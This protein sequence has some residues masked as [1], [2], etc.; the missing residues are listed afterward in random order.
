MVL[1]KRY[2]IE[3]ADRSVECFSDDGFWYTDKGIIIKWIILGV[4]FALFMA[5]FVGGY[6]HA[7]QRLKKGLP[8]LGY[9]RFL[10]SYSE[11]KRHGQVP[12]NHFT[13]Y[14][15]EQPYYPQGQQPPYAQRPG[16]GPYAEPPPMYNNADAPPQ[17]FAPPGASKA[18]P[19]QQGVEMP[20]YGAPV[21]STPQGPQQS[22]VVGGDVEQ[23]QSQALP[24]RPQQA[25]E[26]LRGIV[27]RF[28][29]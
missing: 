9:H 10:I 20:Q 4:I 24:P 18:S 19:N 3:Y 8:L 27:G 28:R 29:R 22:G 11:R 17:Y 25:K 2:C 5:W 26:K 21:Y 14:A 1:Q 7:K 12:Q 16:A 13:F 23:G 15:Q 6:I